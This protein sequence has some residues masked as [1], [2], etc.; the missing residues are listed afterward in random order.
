M[1]WIR[2][3]GCGSVFLCIQGEK[4]HDKLKSGRNNPEQEKD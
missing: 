2:Y 1:V 4:F 3:Y